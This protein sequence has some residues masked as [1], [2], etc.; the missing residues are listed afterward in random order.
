[1][2]FPIICILLLTTCACNRREDLPTE[3]PPAA[4]DVA[5][6]MQPQPPARVSPP[7]EVKRF[8]PPKPPV[9]SI[10]ES[11][12]IMDAAAARARSQAQQLPEP[13]VPLHPA[14]PK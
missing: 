8:E 5:R 3:V 1:M 9:Q 11:F 12:K 10:E 2:R 13:I 6:K 7:A 4:F 14:K